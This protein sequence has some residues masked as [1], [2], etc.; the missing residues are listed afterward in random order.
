LIINHDSME[1][2]VVAV[3]CEIFKFDI[4]FSL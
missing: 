2:V 1:L 3:S 4:S